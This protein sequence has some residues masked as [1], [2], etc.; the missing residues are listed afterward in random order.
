MQL[1]VDECI[2]RST[3][4]L[5]K[6][7]GYDV[8]EIKLI[9][10]RGADDEEIFTYASQKQIPIITHDRRFGEI[11]FDYLEKS[12]TT[13]IL[14]NIRPHPE[15]TNELLESALSQIDLQEEKVKGRLILIDPQKI[16]IRGKFTDK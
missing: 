15:A 8:I 4:R 3:I 1:I 13:L 10:G 11:Y 16:R 14:R 6:E 5:L 9:L 12:T 7:L 2:S